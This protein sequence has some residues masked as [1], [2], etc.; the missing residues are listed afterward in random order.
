METRDV[1]AHYDKISATVESG[2]I[3]TIRKLSE[4]IL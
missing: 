3:R 1:A 4:S 2:Y